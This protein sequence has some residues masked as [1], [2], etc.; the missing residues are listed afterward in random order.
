MPNVSVYIRESRTRSY[1]KANPKELYPPGT[2]FVL[3][4]EEPKTGKRKWETL[5]GLMDIRLAT[6][7]AKL[8]ERR[9]RR[10]GILRA[11]RAERPRAAPTP[12]S[13]AT[14]AE[15]GCCGLA[16]TGKRTACCRRRSRYRRSWRMR[17]SGPGATRPGR[18]QRWRR[19]QPTWRWPPR[20]AAVAWLSGRM[21]RPVRLRRLGSTWRG[22]LDRDP[23]RA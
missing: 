12:L 16:G 4:Y 10:A 13:P 8:K 14:R 17:R 20:P 2:V 22:W 7:K 1:I 11:A 9:A 19:A 23:R 6:V 18:S 3:R 21:R 15:R 5:D